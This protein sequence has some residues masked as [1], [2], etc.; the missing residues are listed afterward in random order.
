M[1]EINRLTVH[2]GKKL[3]LN[4]INLSLNKG[5]FFALVGKNG[6]GKSTLLRAIGSLLTYEGNISLDGYDVRKMTYCDRARK[7]SYLPQSVERVPFSVKELVSFGRNPYVGQ[8][9]KAVLSANAAIKQAGIEYLQNKRVDEMSGG[10]RQ[11]CY[12]AMNLCQ[13]ASLML[14]DEPTANLDLCHEAKIL[15]A[16]KD[17]TNSGKTAIVSMHNLSEAIKYADEIIIL[18]D[19]VCKFFGSKSKCL[20]KEAIETIF[21]VRRFN[22]GNNVFFSV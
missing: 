13:N 5:A 12:F 1:L 6:S 21:G 22:D 16:V 7:I 14:L 9:E 10:E 11:L 19:G 20:E 18:D 2:Y 4:D 3:A 8:K 15:S 17:E